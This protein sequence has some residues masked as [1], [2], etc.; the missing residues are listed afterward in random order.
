[1]RVYCIVDCKGNLIAAYP[2][3]GTAKT[4]C[5]KEI[6]DKVVV[7][8]L[9]YASFPDCNKPAKKAKKK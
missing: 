6:K 2:K 1:M 8:S 9:S 4:M 7:G 3:I 5:R